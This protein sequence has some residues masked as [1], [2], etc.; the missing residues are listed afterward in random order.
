MMTA[1]IQLLV[2]LMK[3]KPIYR[4]SKTTIVTRKSHLT[5]L[6]FQPTKRSDRD[7]LVYFQL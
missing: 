5:L 1:M 4:L 3:K 6:A 7:Y 2:I